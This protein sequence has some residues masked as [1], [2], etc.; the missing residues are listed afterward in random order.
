MTSAVL[1]ELA[2]E[3]C[4]AADP[5]KLNRM[6]ERIPRARFQGMVKVHDEN[7]YGDQVD[8]I[9][10][11]LQRRGRRADGATPSAR[12]KER[13]IWAASAKPA[14]CAASVSDASPETM[15]AA[16]RCSRNQER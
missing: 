16:A 3:A 2:A 10:W 6:N 13:L 1:N 14:S 15:A 9:N 8:V 12:L 11:S 4:G 5:A 7:I